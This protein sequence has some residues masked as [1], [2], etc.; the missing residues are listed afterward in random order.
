MSSMHQ[1]EEQISA[2][3]DKLIAVLQQQ[4]AELSMLYEHVPAG[5]GIFDHNL[6]LTRANQ[7]LS[8]LFGQT[9]AAFIEQTEI[10][11][12][13]SSDALPLLQ[14]VLESGE[15]LTDVPFEP[16]PDALAGECCLSTTL[17]ASYLPLKND[18][19]TWGVCVIV[20]EVASTTFDKNLLIKEKESLEVQ[21][22]RRTEMLEMLH[23]IATYVHETE[24]VEQAIGYV[25]RRV[26]EFNGWSFGHAY[27]VPPENTDVLI[28]LQVYYERHEGS[29]ARLRELTEN[30]IFNIG[31]GLPG[32]ALKNR[33]TVWANNLPDDL[34][35]LRAAWIDEIPVKSAAA[36]PVAI[37]ERIEIVLEFFCV[38]EIPNDHRLSQCMINVSIHLARTIERL[39]AETHLRESE[40]RFRDL[41]ESLNIVFWIWDPATNKLVYLSPY[42]SK[43]VGIQVPN[44]TS[45]SSQLWR[46]YIHQHD[47]QRVDQEFR[48][49]AATGQYE[50]FYRIVRDDGEIRWVQDTAI[51]VRDDNNIVTRIIGIAKDI[52]EMR[53]LER[54]IADVSTREKQRLSR[55]LHDSL[56]QELTGLTMMTHQLTQTLVKSDPDRAA[57]ANTLLEGLRR[58]LQQVRRISRGLAP[59][60]IEA[61]G[62]TVAL[63]QLAE[64]T[65]LAATSA[66]HFRCEGHIVIDDPNVANHLY[67][68]AQE[69]VSNAVKYAQAQTI[70]M[71]LNSNGEFCELLVKDN[72]SGIP[73]VDPSDFGGM[74]L[75]IMRYRADLINGQFVLES[76][77]NRGTLI[78]C[79]VRMK[80]EHC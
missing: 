22:E 4:F 69:A 72:G 5:I 21:I 51:P 48:E 67:R 64:Q 77:L 54:E 80:K 38:H 19:K 15:A 29:F 37:N 68:I 3:R 31:E 20:T 28:P 49:K 79:R 45:S 57:M 24:S 40:E 44:T 25:L 43:I 75:K 9:P 33:T 16:S 78:K 32:R 50:I 42:W 13:I 62:L 1:R 56:G 2:D 61:G 36:F 39:R 60:D 73:D 65:N 8:G 66:C 6:K 18:N 27:V 23:H 71:I 76:S 63:A 70:T 35:P 58:L 10:S 30:M 74:G 26:S 46:K 11:G 53:E 55:D 52:T 59:V 14:T 34:V 41:V 17:Q 7:W 12:F 47:R